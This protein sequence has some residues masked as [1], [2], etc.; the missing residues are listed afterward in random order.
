MNKICMRITV[1]HGRSLGYLILIYHRRILLN[2]LKTS[3][4]SNKK[5]KLKT[6]C[7]KIIRKLRIRIRAVLAL[8]NPSPYWECGS[9]CRF[10]SKEIDQNLTNRSNIKPFKKAFVPTQVCFMAYTTGTYK[11]FLSCKTSA[12]RDGKA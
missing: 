6:L 11:K 1:L 3:T 10:R 9:G 5:K 2:F 8:L 4:Y 12:F 7:L